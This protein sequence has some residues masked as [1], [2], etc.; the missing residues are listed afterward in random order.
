MYPVNTGGP[1]FRSAGYTLAIALGLQLLPVQ[2]FGVWSTLFGVSYERAVRLHRW[3][4]PVIVALAGVHSFGMLVTYAQSSIDVGAGYLA[5]VS[6]H[7]A[8]FS[9]SQN[10]RFPSEPLLTFSGAQEMQIMR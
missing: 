10:Y 1:P 7:L 4:G 9:A 6:E 2:R 8:S 5:L 3:L